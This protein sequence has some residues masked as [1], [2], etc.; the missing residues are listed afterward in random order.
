[1]DLSKIYDRLKYKNHSKVTLLRPCIGGRIRYVHRRLV[2]EFPQPHSEGK[3]TSLRESLL[4]LDPNIPSGMRVDKYHI[5]L[6]LLL[7]GT[8]HNNPDAPAARKY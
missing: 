3:T 2:L 8:L 1:M 7:A 6:F 4:I 5:E